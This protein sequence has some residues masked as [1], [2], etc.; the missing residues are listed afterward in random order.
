MRILFLEQEEKPGREVVPDNIEEERAHLIVFELGAWDGP[1]LYK[2]CLGNL[3]NAPFKPIVSS[4][5]TYI[6]HF[7]DEVVDPLLWCSLRNAWFH[8]RNGDKINGRTI[9]QD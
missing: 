1:W 7:F 3:V 6:Q 5:F 2:I 9:P 8:C 4:R